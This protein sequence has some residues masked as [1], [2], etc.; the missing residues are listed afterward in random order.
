MWK[1]AENSDA[2]GDAAEKKLEGAEA[3]NCGAGAVAEALP[4]VPVPGPTQLQPV[5]GVAVMSEPHED[6]QINDADL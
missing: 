5:A 1:K 3:K 2:V 4:E 6:S